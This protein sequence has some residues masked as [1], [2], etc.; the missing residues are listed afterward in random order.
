MGSLV[1]A[2]LFGR[3]SPI[4]TK[5]VRLPQAGGCNDDFVMII[6]ILLF[7]EN[8]TL[9]ITLEVADSTSDFSTHLHTSG[10]PR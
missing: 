7:L 3:S 8:H 1:R 9:E 6:I 2:T 4:W 10:A 5:A